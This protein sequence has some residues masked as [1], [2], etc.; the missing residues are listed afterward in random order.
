MPGP[1]PGFWW[2]YVLERADG[3]WYT[4]ISTNPRRRFE[5]HRSGKGGANANKIS[6]P[7]PPLS[8]EAGGEYPKALRREA[9]IKKLSKAQKRLYVADPASLAWPD[10]KA[11]WLNRIPK[12]KKKRRR[13]S[14]RIIKTKKKGKAVLP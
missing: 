12:P 4:G 14:V 6:A 7:P 9:Q 13:K 1:R 3:S 11:P 5:Q 8:L 10:E 2:V